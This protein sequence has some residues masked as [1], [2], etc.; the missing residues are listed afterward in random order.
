M[1]PEQATTDIF[2]AN[3]L[4]A[5]GI[6]AVL[7]AAAGVML[8]D[9]GLVRRKNAI[10]S[11]V[12]KL[13]S[14]FVCALGFA[15][16]GYAVWVWQVNQAFE[17][18]NPL[19]QAIG[20]WSIWGGL[21]NHLSTDIDPSVA[22]G[23]DT[24]QVFYVLFVVFA[25][26]LGMV[27]HAAGAERMKP[28]PLYVLSFV[29][30]AVTFPIL[31]YLL[32]GSTSI[33]TNWGVHDNVGA[34]AVYMPLGV[35]SLIVAKM[36]GPRIG[37]FSGGK[38]GDLPGPTNVPLVAI[39][40]A[41]VLPA[42]SFF[43]L[44][45]GYLIPEVGLVGIS[46]GSSTMGMVLMNL[47]GAILG[48][49]IVGAIMSYRTRHATWAIAGPF[50]GYIAGTPI[51][52]VGRPWYMF[53]IGAGAPLVAYLTVQIL[54][55]VKIDE[56]KIVPLVLGPVVYGAIV[57][58]FAAWGEKTG[59]WFEITEGTYAF[60][61]AE[62]TPFKQ[63]VGVAVVFLVAGVI[64]TVVLSIMKA[65]TGLRVREEEEQEGLDATYWPEE[66]PPEPPPASDLGPMPTP[67]LATAAP[68]GY[69]TGT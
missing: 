26:F 53:L 7:M 1:Y 17:I 3:L 58:G 43:V 23:A 10:D 6:L 33:L 24:Y 41:L 22:A 44:V 32:W 57:G 31:L 55:R 28:L 12:Q 19:G 36:V 48:G 63:L 52:D 65:V 42:L 64:T 68:P 15:P 59:G 13:V 8:F 62:I 39:G 61:H 47:W 34:F 49:G 54:E 66:Y 46:M 21:V 37:R 30:G 29:T 2:V 51:Y 35:T 56:G 11:M 38:Q 14:G 50:V 5:I 9:L 20:D 16:M 67:G 4:Y 40:V 60:Q 25:F 27:L 69:P 18:P 45:A